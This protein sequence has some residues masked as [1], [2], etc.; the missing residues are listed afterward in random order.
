MLTYGTE[1]VT[2]H[3]SGESHG[4]YRSASIG[5]TLIIRSALPSGM[6]SECISVSDNLR[7]D[8]TSPPLWL[9]PC[10]SDCF[11]ERF[12]ST[13]ARRIVAAME[14]MPCPPTPASIMSHFI[15]YLCFILPGN[16]SFLVSRR[17]LYALPAGQHHRQ[18]MMHYRL[19]DNGDVIFMIFS[20]RRDHPQVVTAHPKAKAD[21][22][23]PVGCLRMLPSRHA[24]G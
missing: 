4:K 3:P 5:S 13:A 18:S 20:Q 9:I 17:S 14:R 19:P 21:A 2:I 16:F 6:R 7:C 23:K 8:C 11:R 10:T 15:V 22:F 24:C 1:L 12:F